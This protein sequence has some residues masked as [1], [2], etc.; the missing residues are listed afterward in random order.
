MQAPHKHK[1]QYWFEQFSTQLSHFSCFLSCT[2]LKNTNLRTLSIITVSQ[3]TQCENRLCMWK[4]SKLFVFTHKAE[5]SRGRRNHFSRTLDFFSHFPCVFHDWKID[6]SFSR[7]YRTTL[8]HSGQAAWTPSGPYEECNGKKWMRCGGG[9]WKKGRSLGG[10]Y[11]NGWGWSGCGVALLLKLHCMS[12][13]L[14]A[15]AQQQDLLRKNIDEQSSPVCW[16]PFAES[17]KTST[18]PK[19]LQMKTESGGHLYVHTAL[20]PHF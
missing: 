5:R 7:F 15:G 16:L 9:A 4:P 3:F 18:P 19:K 8:H 12:L 13:T 17:Y 11:K 1:R 14:L 6:Q 10:I 20:L 2:F